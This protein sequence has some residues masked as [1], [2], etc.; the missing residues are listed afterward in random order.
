[1]VR[2][3]LVTL[4]SLVLTAGGLWLFA[5]SPLPDMLA[6]G[7][8]DLSSGLMMTVGAALALAAAAF[9]VAFSRTAAVVTGIA[10]LLATAL[11]VLAVLS[12]AL[13]IA[14]WAREA[15]AWHPDA[16][17]L[18]GTLFG[19]GGGAVIGVAFVTVA[20]LGGRAWPTVT[21]R[22][23]SAAG[24]LVAL[25]AA[26]TVVVAGAAFGAGA[27]DGLPL[28]LRPLYIATIALLFLIMVLMLSRASVIVLVVSGIGLVIAAAVV[29]MTPAVLG[30]AIVEPAAP[31]L[32]T[33]VP[34]LAGAAFVGLA[35]GIRLRRRRHP[36]PPI[37]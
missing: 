14:P 26:L 15:F 11:A 8:S 19:C 18:A 37:I 27:A 24:G 13:G 7:R 16:E 22:I 32:I 30:L 35:V 20:S 4:A 3:I 9:L 28:E 10:L 34:L 33:G 2:R 21:A 23:A 25:A 5:R 36:L 17:T 12:P 6:A 1:M 31:V 29:W